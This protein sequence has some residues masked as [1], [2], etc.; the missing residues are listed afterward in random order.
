MPHADLRLIAVR[1]QQQPRAAAGLRTVQSFDYSPVSMAVLADRTTLTARRTSSV[2]DTTYNSRTVITVVRC[3]NATSPAQAHREARS[4]Y[5]RYTFV[6]MP[7]LLT[8]CKVLA[9]RAEGR[10]QKVSKLHFRRGLQLAFNARSM[11]QNRSEDE[12]ASGSALL[13]KIEVPHASLIA[14]RTGSHVC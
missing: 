13:W 6:A 8:G 4:L 10:A 12:E 2:T 1:F 11:R 3:G 5:C 14:S 7:A 9:K